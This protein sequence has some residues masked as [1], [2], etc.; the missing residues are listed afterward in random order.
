MRYAEYTRAGLR[1]RAGTA[2]AVRTRPQRDTIDLIREAARTGLY[3]VFKPEDNDTWTLR[4]FD[5]A[6]GLLSEPVQTSGPIGA[7]STAAIMW[8]EDLEDV[9]GW[10]SMSRPYPGAYIDEI[11]SLVREIARK[12]QS[13]RDIV[14]HIE[15]DPSLPGLA[16]P[17][18]ANGGT[19]AAWR[20][21]RST[22]AS[23]PGS[24]TTLTCC[25]RSAPGSAW[26]MKD[27]RRSRQG[28]STAIP[29]GAKN[30]WGR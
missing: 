16:L 2:T 5:D 24:P 9:S 13:G 26:M 21:T 4:Q 14:V 7:G 30:R 8:A 10:Q 18:C 20:A 25:T 15:T 27:G 1:K 6:T 11:Y 28:S 29:S 17:L 3:W 19:R 22:S 12:P 23:T